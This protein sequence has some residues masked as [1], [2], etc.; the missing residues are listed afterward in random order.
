MPRR[1]RVFAPGLLY[2]VIARGNHRQATF[3]TGL[4][5]RAYLHRLARYQQRYGVMLY[6]Y[7]LMPNHVHLLVQTSDTPLAKF[8]QGLQQSYTQRFNR[9]HDKVGH[10]FQSRYKA[11]VCDR[12]DYLATLVRYIHLNPVRAGLVRD[13]KAYRYSA[14]GAYLVGDGRGLVEPGP[15]LDMLG[16]QAGYQRFMDAAIDAGVDERHLETEDQPRPGTR[17]FAQRIG[18]LAAQPAGGVP[19][20][21]LDLAV[22]ELARRFAVDPDEL[23]SPDRSHRISRARAAASFILIRRLGYAVADVATALGRDSATISV[24]A[25][26]WARRPAG[27]AEI[28][29][30]TEMFKSQSLTPR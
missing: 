13:P 12:N 16:G 22:R 27:A 9:V 14:H 4:D 30:S 5:Y 1:R 19:R 28:G 6:A 8:M 18:H 17:G 26:R 15:V 23:R 3:L 25:S 11:I 10:L 24:I 20:A 29:L 2:H 21:P 7:C